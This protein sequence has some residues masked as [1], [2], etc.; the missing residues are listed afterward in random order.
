MR[1]TVLTQTSSLTR[2]DPLFTSRKSQTPVKKKRKKRAYQT[3]LKNYTILS[4]LRDVH[5][6]QL[7][8]YN[9]CVPSQQ[10]R[11]VTSAFRWISNQRCAATSQSILYSLCLT[12]NFGKFSK[13]TNVTDTLESRI[14]TLSLQRSSAFGPNLFANN[15]KYLGNGSDAHK[16]S[17]KLV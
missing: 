6:F 13:R 8:P 11:M 17:W 1:Q 7:A 3:V 14:L 12:I 10:R 2:T 15:F 5:L 16:S 9:T 4:L